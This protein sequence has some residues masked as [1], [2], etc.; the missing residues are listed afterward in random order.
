MLDL[1]LH[2]WGHKKIIMANTRTTDSSPKYTTRPIL[3]IDDANRIIPY[4]YEYRIDGMRTEFTS[5]Y[6]LKVVYRNDLY[7]Q[8]KYRNALFPDMS[9]ML[10]NI[11]IKDF[12][13]KYG[14]KIEV[15]DSDTFIVSIPKVGETKE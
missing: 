11:I 9:V 2:N 6:P 15:V 10:N 8:K 14:L 13:S 7:P 3:L 12:F 1:D 4:P 5:V